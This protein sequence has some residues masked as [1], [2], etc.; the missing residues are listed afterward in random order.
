M[1][2][3]S[4][5]G[6]VERTQPGLFAEDVLGVRPR[7]HVIADLIDACSELVQRPCLCE[8]RR[9]NRAS[10][11]RGD[12]LRG[13]LFDAD[14]VLQHADLE[15]PLGAATGEDERGRTGVG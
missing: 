3:A 5:R 9:R 13:D 4:E 1:D 8:H 11:G 14:E 7:Q 10:R 6:A 12:D 2:L 15:R